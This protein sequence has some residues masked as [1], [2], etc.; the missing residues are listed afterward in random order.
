MDGAH[1]WISGK[2]CSLARQGVVLHAA[3]E[4]L[5]PLWGSPSHYSSFAKLHPVFE[6]CCQGNRQTCRCGAHGAP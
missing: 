5:V 1:T 2:L 3:P 4:P 6:G